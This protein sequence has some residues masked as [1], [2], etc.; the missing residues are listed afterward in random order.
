[1]PSCHPGQ[2]GAR[3]TLLQ[4]SELKLIWLPSFFIFD[5][6][7]VASDKQSRDPEARDGDGHRDEEIDDDAGFIGSSPNLAQ[8]SRSPLI[9]YIRNSAQLRTAKWPLDGLIETDRMGLSCRPRIRSS[10]GGDHVAIVRFLD[11]FS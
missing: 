6:L 11:S 3:T 5:W 4:E 9:E 1:M 2:G 10:C 7:S 8:P